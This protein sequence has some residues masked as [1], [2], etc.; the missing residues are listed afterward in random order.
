MIRWLALLLVVLVLPAPG[1]AAS[2]A[3]A[4]HASGQT[5]VWGFDAPATG[6]SVVAADD[7]DRDD[8]DS[9]PPAP[10]RTDD[11]LLAASGAFAIRPGDVLTAALLFHDTGLRPAR[12]HAR[13]LELPP[14]SA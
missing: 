12:G 6:W 11:D 5:A 7:D 4:S 10:E 1:V 14:R 8:D 9:V 3:H 2:P 13:V